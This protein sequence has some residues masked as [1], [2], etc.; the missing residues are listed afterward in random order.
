MLNLILK[1]TNA[2]NLR[3][4]YCSLGEKKQVE[5]LGAS[6]MSKALSWF[7]EYARKKNQR[8][9]QIILHGGEPFLVP[10]EQ[11]RFCFQE[12]QEK[13][14][15]VEIC[16]S[17]QT[18]GYELSEDY[19][20]LIRDYKIRIGVSLDGG[21]EVHDRQRKGIC[22]EGTYE[23]VIGNIHMLKDNSIPVSVLMVITQ[24]HQK[25]DFQFFDFLAREKI[26]VKVNPLYRV[27]EAEKN[28]DLALPDG[29]YGQFLIDLFEH[30][31]NDGID[32]HVSPLEELL[33]AIL[34][35]NTPRGCSFCSSCIDSFICIN[36]N[37][38]IY[39]CGRFS[40][41]NAFKIGSID[42]GISREGSKIITEIKSRRRE[43]LASKCIHCKYLRLCNS[44]CSA[45]IFRQGRPNEPS[46]L[47]ED[48]FMVFEYLSGSGLAKYKQY[49]LKKRTDLQKELAGEASG[50]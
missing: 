32:L 12:L 2:C 10:A 13:Y 42:T 50:L 16:Y 9:V 34:Y 43:E 33:Q 4:G 18:N 30:M 44:G 26:P 48:Y 22:G 47:C 14:K 46:E 19:V 24:Y 41:C 15:D 11:Y 23:K 17:A 25:M 7:L 36:Q 31:L 45:Y 28:I 35:G 27:G 40:D 5:M 6:D 37:G 20:E 49:L 39:P 1:G 21:K 8:R 3:C 29:Y 38:E